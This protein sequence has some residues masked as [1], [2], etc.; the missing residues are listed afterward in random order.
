LTLRFAYRADIVVDDGVLIEVKAVE[1]I[2][3]VWHPQVR[4]YLQ[5]GDY[6]GGLLL[7]FGAA[8][9]LEGIER[10]VNDFPEE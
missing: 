5:L 1:T 10:I 4:T 7:N 8:T 6:R 3:P 9:M 2:N